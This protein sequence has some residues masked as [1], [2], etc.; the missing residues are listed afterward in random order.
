MTK[1][2]IDVRVHT[3]IDNRVPVENIWS[4]TLLSMVPVLG[5]S[6]SLTLV[7]YALVL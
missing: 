7:H 1:N 2:L 5:A 4:S 6:G 3:T